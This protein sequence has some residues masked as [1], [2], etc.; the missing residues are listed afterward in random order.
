MKRWHLLLEANYLFLLTFLL[1]SMT[2]SAADITE[3]LHRPFDNSVSQ[4]SRDEADNLVRV[5]EEQLSQGNSNKAIQSWLQALGIYH[6]IGD[7]KAQGLTYDFLGKEYVQLNLL[8]KAEDTLRR[9]LAIAR[10]VNDFQAQ[11]FG[12]NNIGSLLLQKGEPVAASQTFA[13]ALEIAQNLKN[14]EGEG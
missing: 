5:G 2:V 14:I 9:R 13:E 8:K 6:S 3:Q 10:D 4:Q 12:L 1:N 7:L 11:I